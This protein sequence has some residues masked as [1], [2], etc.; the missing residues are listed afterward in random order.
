MTM[1]P[2]EC[3]QK[4]QSSFGLYHVQAKNHKKDDQKVKKW[5]KERKKV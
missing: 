2:G 1:H 4:M 3:F 5:E